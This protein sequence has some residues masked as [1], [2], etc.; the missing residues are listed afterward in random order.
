MTNLTHDATYASGTSTR[1]VARKYLVPKVGVEQDVA[2]AERLI[3]AFTH[4][5]TSTVWEVDQ[6]ARLYLIAVSTGDNKYA[7]SVHPRARAGGFSVEPISD[8]VRAQAA[9]M[10]LGS[11]MSHAMASATR[12]IPRS[13]RLVWVGLLLFGTVAGLVA[14]AS[15]TGWLAVDPFSALMGLGGTGVL[16]LT[17]WKLGNGMKSGASVA[18]RV[19]RE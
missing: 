1:E 11:F 5:R 9:S 13:Y 15:F 8:S 3:T 14:G 2:V 18:M 4:E 19:R 7:V 16:A 17:A 10:S 6:E 12:F